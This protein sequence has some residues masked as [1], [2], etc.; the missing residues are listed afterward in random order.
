[1]LKKRLAEYRFPQPD[2]W[3]WKWS[4][5]SSETDLLFTFKNPF[6][7][8]PTQGIQIP[9][10]VLKRFLAREGSKNGKYR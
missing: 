3:E 8:T 5:A 6:I 4:I 2:G 7:H 9:K 1:M 10:K